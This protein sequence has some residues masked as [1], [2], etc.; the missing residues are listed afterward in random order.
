MKN[1]IVKFKNVA[2]ECP[3]VDGD[4]YVAVRP[5]CDAIG[6]NSQTQ[7]EKLKIGLNGTSVEGVMMPSTGA[8]GKTYEM[9]CIPLKYVFGWLMMIE[10][11]KV[12]EDVR[13]TLIAYKEECHQV[14]YEHFFLKSV[15]YERKEREIAEKKLAIA[16]AKTQMYE[17]KSS[18]AT[19]KEELEQLI[20]E[21]VGQTKLFD[22]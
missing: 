1:E 3:K 11:D 20:D 4:I 7:I 21:P 17:L 9:F 14:L 16:E 13:E 10:V 12:K 19:M 18:I 2:I 8:D 6:I 5:I 15:L 22:E